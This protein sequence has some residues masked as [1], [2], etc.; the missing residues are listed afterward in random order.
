[1]IKEKKGFRE[2]KRKNYIYLGCINCDNKVI[3]LIFI[4]S[5]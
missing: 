5:E 2:E 4:I 3:I 1:M